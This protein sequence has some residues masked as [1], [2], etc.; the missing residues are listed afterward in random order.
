MGFDGRDDQLLDL[1]LNQLSA[2]ER[3]E[4]E[5]ELAENEELR[6]RSERLG[7][8]LRPLDHWSVSAGPALL[9]EKVLRTVS[10]ARRIPRTTVAVGGSSSGGRWHFLAMRDFLAV[11]ACL[12]LLMSVMLPGLSHVRSRTQR[13]VCTENLRSIYAGL[14]IYRHVFDESL[15]YAGGV[16]SASWLPQASNA[17]P[18]SSNSRHVFRLL[19]SEIGLMS[20]NFVC[21][22]LGGA[23]ETHED[24]RYRDDF[25]TAES[26]SYDSLNLAGSNP[27]LRQVD[28]DLAYLGDPNPLFLGRRFH[29]DLDPDK[30]NSPAHAGVGQTVLLLDGSANM[31]YKPV[32]N[33]Q[34]DN[35]WTLKGVRNYVGTEV[36]R[37]SGDSF[38]VPGR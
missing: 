32:A 30:T 9:P 4:L 26:I 18:F 16:A 7:Q 23:V 15:P 29:A 17:I 33:P 36:R 27:E 13:S 14:G 35:F 31:Y 34:S 5:R 6:T 22:S 1:H 11:A 12:V 3:L 37:G 28:A 10:G 20:S 25:P 21:P 8:I 38:L 24:L 2:E 19:R